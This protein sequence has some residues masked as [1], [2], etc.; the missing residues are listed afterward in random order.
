MTMEHHEYREMIR[1]L[2]EKDLDRAGDQ[3]LFAHLR[4]CEGCE[5]VYQRWATAEQAFAGDRLAS[6]RVLQRVLEPA[7]SAGPARSTV[8]L[9]GPAIVALGLVLALSFRPVAQPDFV[10]RGGAAEVSLA[11]RVL[12][13]RLEGGQA[14]V[15]DLV[16]GSA[17][18]AGD[19]LRILCSSAAPL[20]MSAMTIDVPSGERVSLGDSVSVGA[21]AVEA[22]VGEI[23]EVTPAWGTG[24]ATLR[25]DEV[26]SL[27]FTVGP[28]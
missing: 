17:V 11:F 18:Q 21:G 2:F 15:S 3:R 25:I 6:E 8:W 26:F 1:R 5:H 19:H 22:P 20:T 24:S 13:I 14:Q 16:P 4:E 27:P 28:R 7:P 12:L 9:I 23:I 10:A